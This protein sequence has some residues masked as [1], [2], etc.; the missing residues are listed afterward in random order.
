[1]SHRTTPPSGTGKTKSFNHSVEAANPWNRRTIRGSLRLR[2]CLDACLCAELEAAGE[3]CETAQVRTS[4]THL[5]DESTLQPTVAPC[6]L[7]NPG[8]GTRR[9]MWSSIEYD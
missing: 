3:T 8:P 5:V 9:P 6:F 4:G 7:L 2:V 1:M